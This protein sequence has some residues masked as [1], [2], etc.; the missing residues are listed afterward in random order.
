[1]WFKII[2]IFKN[3]FQSF[4]QLQGRSHRGHINEYTQIHKLQIEVAID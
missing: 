3:I 4:Y 1:M 2:Y